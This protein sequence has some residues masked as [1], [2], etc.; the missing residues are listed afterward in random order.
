M[1]FQWECSNE[2]RRPIVSVNRSVDNGNSDSVLLAA[3]TP[4]VENCYNP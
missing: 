3:V 1:Q 2:A 4:S